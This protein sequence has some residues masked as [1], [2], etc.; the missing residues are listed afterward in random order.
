[1]EGWQEQAA[2]ALLSLDLPALAEEPL[3]FLPDHVPSLVQLRFPHQQL[4][5][6]EVGELGGG[7]ARL[8]VDLIPQ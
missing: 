7:C 5:V 1:M 8:T 4:L 6:A 2:P 3:M